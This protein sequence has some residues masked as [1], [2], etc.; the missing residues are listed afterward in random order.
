MAKIKYFAGHGKR[1]DHR[2]NILAGVQAGVHVWHREIEE[3][4]AHS[5]HQHD[6]LII[7]H[8]AQTAPRGVVDDHHFTSRYPGGLRLSRQSRETVVE[9]LRP[10]NV[11]LLVTLSLN[12]GDSSDE[13][14]RPCHQCHN[15]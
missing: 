7:R 4:M 3:A 8:R 5:D 13:R 11:G 15:P 12:Q 10:R 1:R 9:Q 2:N 14:Q 6:R